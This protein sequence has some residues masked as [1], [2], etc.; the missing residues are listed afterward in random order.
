MS[1]EKTV[2]NVKELVDNAPYNYGCPVLMLT[3][4]SYTDRIG[5]GNRVVWALACD[6]EVLQLVTALGELHKVPLSALDLRYVLGPNGRKIEHKFN[7]KTGNLMYRLA[8]KKK[9]QDWGP[10]QK[11]GPC[12]FMSFSSEDERVST[13]RGALLGM[14]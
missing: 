6:G 5:H 12:V 11:P 4:F 14:F 2:E 7:K 13:P 10:W 1:R 8:P 3:I 9:W